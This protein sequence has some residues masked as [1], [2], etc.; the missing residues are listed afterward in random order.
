MLLEAFGA[1]AINRVE[2]ETLAEG[3]LAR[4]AVWL[5]GRSRTAGKEARA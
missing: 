1:E 3:L 4:L 5:A 2:D